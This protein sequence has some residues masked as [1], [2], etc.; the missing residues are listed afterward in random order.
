MNTDTVMNNTTEVNNTPTVAVKVTRG[1]E[2]RRFN[3]KGQ[4]FQELKKVIAEI[5]SIPLDSDFTV[6]YEDD[7]KDRVTLS[8]D[9]ELKEAIQIHKYVLRFFVFV[10]NKPVAGEN[11]TPLP[12]SPH[13]LHPF[14]PHHHHRR[15]HHEH[16]HHHGDV[17][18][19]NE[20]QVTPPPHGHHGHGHHARPCGHGP[21]G[22]HHGHGPHGH[23]KRRF[24]KEDKEAMKAEKKRWKKQRKC[25]SSSSEEEAQ[26]KEMKQLIKATKQSIKANWAPVKEAN[27]AQWHENRQLMVA[28][29]KLAKRIIREQANQSNTP[30]AATVATEQNI[31]VVP[32]GVEMQA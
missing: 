10:V 26:K 2:M 3:F 1:D 17:M 19:A 29:I 6:Q 31:S 8:S 18:V 4:S 32:V 15:H 22:H 12:P 28:E 11:N 9:A 30:V 24:D 23:H 25:E 27:P 21:H 5:F 13:H 16:P 20:G 7:E 14:P